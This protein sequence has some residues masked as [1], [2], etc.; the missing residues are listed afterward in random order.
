MH[1]QYTIQYNTIQ[2][3]TIQYNTMQYNTIQYNTIQYNT[4]QYNTIQYNTIQYNTIQYN[5]IQ[6]NTIQY[7]TIQYNTI[8]YN[9]FGPMFLRNLPWEPQGSTSLRAAWGHTLFTRIIPFISVERLPDQPLSI[10]VPDNPQGGG[11]NQEW[12]RGG[13]SMGARWGGSAQQHQ[14]HIGRLIRQRPGWGEHVGAPGVPR[15]GGGE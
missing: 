14:Q 11:P 8:Q 10:P 6:Y 7:N 12:G 13:K 2:Y 15:R 9:T 3:N 4:I 5:T 1:S